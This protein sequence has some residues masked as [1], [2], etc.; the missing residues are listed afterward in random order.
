MAK[1]HWVLLGS[2]AG[3]GAGVMYLLDP[4]GGGQRRALARD[5]AVSAF[6]TSGDS[7]R[8][9][10][11]DLGNRTKGLYSTVSSRLRKEEVSDRKLTARVRSLLGHHVSHP[12]AITVNAEGG[13]V[14]LGGAVLASELADLL[15]AVEAEPGVKGLLNHLE[16]HESA[17]NVPELQDGGL[18]KSRRLPPTARLLAGAAGGALAL[19]ALKRRDPVG[20][21]LG[22]VGLSLLAGSGLAGRNP[23]S[24]FRRSSQGLDDSQTLTAEPAHHEISSVDEALAPA[25]G[26]EE[27]AFQPETI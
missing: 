21:A 24:L 18:L 5:K 15:A 8:K 16:V 27:G 3:V 19:A 7:L 11:K 1:Q 2:G 14:T 20:V 23:A 25:P 9:A 17:D 10:S 26:T 4:V 12:R 6:N 13:T 22:G